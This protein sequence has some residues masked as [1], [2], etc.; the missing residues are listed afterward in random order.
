MDVP[1]ITRAAPRPTAVKPRPAT[2]VDWEAKYIAI[3]S[4]VY[5]HYWLGISTEE[6][7]C[8]AVEPFMNELPPP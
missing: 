3:R 2:V 5:E 6:E 1:M 4:A 7:F 8:A